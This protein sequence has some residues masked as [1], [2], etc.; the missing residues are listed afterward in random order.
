MSIGRIAGFKLVAQSEGSSSKVREFCAHARA[1][2]RAFRASFERKREGSAW[3]EAT[4]KAVCMV[5]F[6][7]ILIFSVLQRLTKFCAAKRGE[8]IIHVEEY[9]AGVDFCRLD[10]NVRN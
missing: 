7:E 10:S 3:L 8:A 1:A 5:L 2:A 6:G 4:R 9:S